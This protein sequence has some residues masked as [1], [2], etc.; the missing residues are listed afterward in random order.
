MISLFILTR[1]WSYERIYGIN[2][3][4]CI[5]ALNIRIS[6]AQAGRRKVANHM[7]FCIAQHLDDVLPEPLS[8]SDSAVPPRF[9]LLTNLGSHLHTLHYSLSPSRLQ[10][11]YEF[12]QTRPSEKCPSAEQSDPPCQCR[13]RHPGLCWKGLLTTDVNS[14]GP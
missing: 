10:D 4:I 1:Y 8:D 9:L 3:C 6:I 11:G 5:T 7:D 14:R 13:E 12:T 2:L